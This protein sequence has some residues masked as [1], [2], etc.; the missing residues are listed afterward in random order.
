M[1]DRNN[2][3]WAPFN[4]VINGQDV[5]KEINEEK[6]R[7][8][9]PILSEDQLEELENII[10]EVLSNQSTIELIFYRNNHFYKVT[11]KITSVNTAQKKITINNQKSYYFANIIKI[12]IKNT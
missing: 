6:S 9:K 7:I 10:L 11:G 12:I 1:H 3:K 8:N 5:I 4:S 2:I